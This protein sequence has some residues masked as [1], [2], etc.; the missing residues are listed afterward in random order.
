MDLGSNS[1]CCRRVEGSSERQSWPKKKKMGKMLHIANLSK[2]LLG[3]LAR[4]SR[5]SAIIN[6]GKVSEKRS[7][8]NGDAVQ[9]AA[10]KK[11][12]A[13]RVDKDGRQYRFWSRTGDKRIRKS[14]PVSY[15]ESEKQAKETGVNG[16][17]LSS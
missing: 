14:G 3:L 2:R 12:R 17:L 9:R 11:G 8:V 15:Q 5:G 7:A 6:L 16:H 10:I 1:D 13:G 4:S